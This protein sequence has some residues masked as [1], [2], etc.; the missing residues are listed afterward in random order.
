MTTTDVLVVG[1]GPTGLTLGAALTGRGVK[2]TVV[3]ALPAGANTSRAVA[4]A[5]RTLEVLEQVGASE[6]MVDQGIHVHLFSM[7]D[8]DHQLIPIDFSGLPTKYPYTLT[9]SQAD[10]ERVLLDRLTALGG[11]VLRPKKL[12]GLANDTDLVTATFDD[13]EEIAARYVVGADGMHSI[14]RDQVG[15]GF[16]GHEYPESFALADVRLDG[17]APTDEIL[18]FYAPGGINVIAP[19]PDGTHR[20]VA[21]VPDAPATPAPDF[22]QA[23]LDT[24]GFGPG[25]STVRDVVWGSHFRIHHRVADTYRAGRVL[26]AGDAA[27]VHSPAGGQGMNLGIQDAI[28]LAEALGKVLDGA[29]DGVLDAYSRTRRPIAKQVLA[30]T[31]RLTRLATLPR[32]LNPVRNTAMTLAGHLPVVRRDLAWRLSGLVYR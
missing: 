24:R 13:G 20:I 10:T 2:A 17:R 15:I 32:A 30:L 26:L 21:P 23:L 28:A 6:R 31:D 3:D 9:L 5:A 16:V 25:R 4:V 8:G 11:G 19:L 14:V 27:H 7:R 22:V 12:T 1:A 18:L 29:P